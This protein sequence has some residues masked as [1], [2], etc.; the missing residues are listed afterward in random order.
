MTM[1]RSFPARIFAGLIAGLLGGLL[2]AWL[3]P[4]ASGWPTHLLISACL[5]AIF[6]IA[7]DHRVQSAGA[8]FVWGEAV[9]AIWWL[10]GSLTL[11]P[12]LKGEGLLWTAS[13]AQAAFPQLM[14]LIA[15]FGAPMGF[16][17]FWLV[18]VIDRSTPIPTVHENGARR[19]KPT[20]QEIIPRWLRI[21]ILGGIGGLLGSW[22]FV[23]GLVGTGFYEV[24][25][26]IV[27]AD[28]IAVG[29][30]VHYA[31]GLLIGVSFGLLFDHDEQDAGSGILYGI[32][33][34]LFWWMI[35][36][37]ILLPIL[38]GQEARPYWTIE[39]AR[40]FAPSFVGHV[41]YG[42]LVGLFYG[43]IHSLWRVLF[44]DSDPLN[45]VSEGAGTR[46]LRA[47]LMGQAGGILGGLLFTVIMLGLGV[48]PRVASLVGGSGWVLGFI[49]H[50]VISV[51][52]GS[53]YGLLFY[54]KATSYSAEIGFGLVYGWFW[55]ILGA[56]TL[57]AAI[58][59]QPINW[60]VATI[61]GLY[62]SLIG[63]LLYGA[64][65]AIFF[66]FLARRYDAP[67]PARTQRDLR[68]IIHLQQDWIST[69]AL[70]AV[71]LVTLL[72]GVI[73]PLLM[74]TAGGV[75]SGY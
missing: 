7:L 24:V 30:L 54:R 66:Q 48:L 22:V 64:G 67:P 26:G 2:F 38:L 60:S 32:N 73:V 37:M 6:G 4:P 53:S 49:V 34:G 56:V 29:R 69:R 51:I 50:L 33:Y 8:G 12:L 74:W 9:A 31:I 71:W 47:L 10:G 27:R 41:L 5:G 14:G 68:Q 13:S 75:G 40:L 25:A 61:T 18:R 58:L 46:T 52:I 44:V 15:G 19:K 28:S 23:W 62:P 59:R 36:P 43:A 20:P 1:N 55:W 70:S 39:T 3:V 11:L 42:A 16:A 63:H 65:L 35:G 72:I 21:L 45:R 57:F 17:Y